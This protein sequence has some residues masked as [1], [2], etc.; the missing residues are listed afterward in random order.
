[1]EDRCLTRAELAGFLGVSLRTVDRRVS[2]GSL[3]PPIK[4]GSI[5]RWRLGMVITHLER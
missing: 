1:M 5:S 2:D 4:L 3:P